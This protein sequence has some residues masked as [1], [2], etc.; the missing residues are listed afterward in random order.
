MTR[1]TK[2]NTGIYQISINGRTFEIENMHGAWMVFEIVRGSR[3]YIID[4]NTKREA[5]RSLE[6]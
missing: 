2:I 4:Y 3:E 5:V 6:A 1:A